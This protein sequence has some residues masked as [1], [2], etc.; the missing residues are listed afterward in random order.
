MNKAKITVIPVILISIFILTCC[1]TV[2][3][4]PDHST[5]TD[6]KI[7]DSAEDILYAYQKNF[8]DGTATLN[9]IP[10]DLTQELYDNYDRLQ[11]EGNKK[12]PILLREYA[13]TD[14]VYFDYDSGYSIVWEKGSGEVRIEE[15]DIEE[16]EEFR[17]KQHK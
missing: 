16:W 5:E 7:I 11:E 3:A 10:V 17:Q 13:V 6:V 15:T 8:A 14:T 12:A 9:I 4:T 1:S 2:P